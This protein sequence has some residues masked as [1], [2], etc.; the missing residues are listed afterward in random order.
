MEKILVMNFPLEITA[1]S[2]DTY[3]NT[4]MFKLYIDC[5]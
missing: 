5:P 1:E 2:D 3:I 4:Y